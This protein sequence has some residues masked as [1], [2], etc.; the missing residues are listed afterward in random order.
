MPFLDRMANSGLVIDNGILRRVARRVATQ[1]D[2]LV[3]TSARRAAAHRVRSRPVP[4]RVVVVC[5]G[6]ICRSPYAAEALRRRLA[7]FGFDQVEVDSVGFIGPGR[8][9]HEQAQSCGARRGA[10]L[11]RHRSRL[12]L[13]EDAGADLLLAMT[14]D[15]RDLLVRTYGIADRIELLA[16]F[17]LDDPPAREIADPYG[18]DDVEFNRVFDQID[19]SIAGLVGLWRGAKREASDQRPGAG[20]RAW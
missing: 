18:A 10:D 12:F 8:P 4:R 16:D 13:A 19:R 3:H 1:V 5:Y 17:D 11:T 9:A 15:H 2:R 7:E 20:G 14:R 6:N